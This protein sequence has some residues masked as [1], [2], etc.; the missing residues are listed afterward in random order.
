M[1]WTRRSNISKFIQAKEATAYDNLLLDGR[2]FNADVR[3]EY[4]GQSGLHCIPYIG[5]YN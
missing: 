4:G 2:I 3:D 1:I 5:K